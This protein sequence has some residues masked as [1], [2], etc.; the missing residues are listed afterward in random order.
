MFEVHAG[1]LA[2]IAET[3]RYDLSRGISLGLGSA[4]EWAEAQPA[5]IESCD[6]PSLS[7]RRLVPG[8]APP[9]I[10]ARHWEIPKIP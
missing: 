7:R 2:N 3:S 6:S 1:T 9:S 10:A 8:Q 4:G 5:Q